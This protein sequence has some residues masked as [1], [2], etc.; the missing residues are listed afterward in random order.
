MADP[1][2]PTAAAATTPHR[3]IETFLRRCATLIERAA[4]DP[5]VDA[6]PAARQPS[7]A[8]AAAL[9]AALDHAEPRPFEST[10]LPCLDTI[11][12]LTP[13]QAADDRA[14]TGSAATGDDGDPLA[15]FVDLAPTLPWLPT[16]RVDDGGAELALAPLDRVFDTG[17]ITIGFMYV[18]PGCQY[19]LHHHPPQ[20]LYLVL[21][22]RG[23]WRYGGSP[24]LRM[25]APLQTLYN[26][27]DDLHTA[28]AGN[29][30][31]AALYVLW[32]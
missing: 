11:D 26:H 31:I 30:P 9:G 10:W 29:E 20:E 32:P 28:I 19:P 21:G 6:D 8:A 12:R 5:A 15:T 23:R 1:T 17:S 13:S 2:E 27:P 4:A 14:T 16:P 18:A 22:G 7:R 3:E 24:E 25:V